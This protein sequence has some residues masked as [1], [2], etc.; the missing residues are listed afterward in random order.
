ML[1]PR[2][3]LLLIFSVLM[4]NA[5]SHH[6]SIDGHRIHYT[7]HGSGSKAIVFIHGW[8]CDHTFWRLDLKALGAGRRVLLVD[9]PGHG[10]SDKPEISYS[11]ALFARAV[12]AVLDHAGVSRAVLAGH[13]MGTPVALTFLEMFPQKTAAIVMVDGVIPRSKATPE[14]REK[15]LARWSGPD[16]KATAEKMIEFMFVPATSAELRGEILRKMLETPRH[17]AASAMAG[18]LELTPPEKIPVPALAILAN[19]PGAPADY[20]Q[21]LRGR[22]EKLDYERWDGAGHFL[23]MEQSERFQKAVVTFLEKH[24]L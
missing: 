18:M 19:R 12:N 21:F 24:G 6:A 9:L 10:L 1:R 4:A 13:S 2:L 20:E 5:A 3:H 15:V 7:S 22:V 16:Y 8:T 14:Q 23:M 11:Q 17:V